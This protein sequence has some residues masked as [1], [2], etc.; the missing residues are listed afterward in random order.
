MQTANPPVAAAS[1]PLDPLTAG[2]IQAASAILRRERGLTPD[3]RFVY[4]SLKEPPKDDV[5]AFT[6][7]AAVDRAAAILLR[8]RRTHAVIEAE[9]SISSGSV[10]AWRELVGVQPS[11]MME[12]TRLTSCLPP[13][14]SQ[15]STPGGAGL[16]AYVVNDRPLENADV[17]LWHTLGAHHITRPEEWLVMPVGY[18]SF[19]LKPDGFFDGNPALD[20]PPAHLSHGD[21]HHHGN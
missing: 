13:A 2:E 20:V 3:H 5:L 12:E 10:T 11:I 8:D 1:H 9:V 6:P 18:A 7:G 4:I 17:V 14:T 16:P 21:G 19:H 15:T